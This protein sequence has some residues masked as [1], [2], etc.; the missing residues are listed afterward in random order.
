MK[1]PKK[2][3]HYSY[4][5]PLLQYVVIRFI[6]AGVQEQVK[7]E[8]ETV[9]TSQPLPEIVSAGDDR[10]YDE[11]IAQQEKLKQQEES[12][13]ADD[14]VY[15]SDGFPITDAE[16][17][18][19]EKKRIEPLPP[20]DHNTISYPKFRKNFYKEHRDVA[21]MNDDE[22]GRLQDELEVHVLGADAPR[23]L[24]KFEHAGFPTQL[25]SEIAKTGFEKPTSIQAQALPIALSGRD[26]I[27]LAKTG[28]GKTLAFVWPM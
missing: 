6:R 21:A 25:T 2:R 14:T 7:K 9:G 12:E 20:V 5:P 23:P 13:T 4:D 8:K 18:A 27:G 15:D 24:F 26:L 28:S 19:G 1:R 17:K 16:A 3:R 22:L 11:Y 10:E